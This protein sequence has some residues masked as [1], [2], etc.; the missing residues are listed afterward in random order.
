MAQRRRRL[1]QSSTAWTRRCARI[2]LEGNAPRRH[3]YAIPLAVA[4]SLV[5]VGLVMANNGTGEPVAWL[6]LV[7]LVLVGCLIAALRTRRREDH[8]AQVLARATP[9][10]GA[11]G[12][13]GE[14][15]EHVIEGETA[16]PLVFHAVEVEAAIAEGPASAAARRHAAGPW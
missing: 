10:R 5:V 13:C 1:R 6:V 3:P 7:A 11:C 15:S 12:W 9:L 4:V 2:F 8:R 14:H 16:H